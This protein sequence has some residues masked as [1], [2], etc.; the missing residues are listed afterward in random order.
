MAKKSS[1]LMFKGQ[2]VG[3]IVAKSRREA[4]TACAAVK[5]TYSFDGE[6]AGVY[7]I[8]QAK[9]AGRVDPP[10]VNKR[11]DVDAEFAKAGMKVVEGGFTIG[12]Q[13]H[14]CMEKHTSMSVPE[15]RGHIQVQCGSQG[16]DVVRQFTAAVLGKSGLEVEVI[17]RRMGGAFGAKFTKGMFVILAS[18]VAA[19]KL[20]VPVKI[21]N[22]IEVDM[23]MGGHCRHPTEITYKAAVDPAT[24]KI[25]AIAWNATM[26]KGCA[27][28]FS[29]FVSGELLN[30]AECLYHVPNFKVTVQLVQT[31]TPSN[32]AVRGPGIPQA[33]A[34]GEQVIEH[35]AVAIGSDIEA[36]RKHNLMSEDSVTM[37]VMMLPDGTQIPAG[38]PLA[39][40][41]Y[42]IPRIFDELT[43]SSN[44]NAR[45]VAIA[46]F[47]SENKWVKR[48][49]ALMPMRYSHMPGFN[50]NTTCTININGPDGVVNVH[51]GGVEMG[52][53]LNTKVAN[54]IAIELGCSLDNV[55][56]HSSST[57]TT[58]NAGII[59]GSVGSETCTA[60]AYKTVKI[61]IDRMAPI[62]AILVE[63]RAAAAK[64]EGKEPVP[65]TFHE[66]VA[67]CTGGLMEGFKICLAASAN[68]APK[69]GL[70][71]GVA[72]TD[73]WEQ[74]P[75]PQGGYLT[76]GAAVSETEVDVLTGDVRVLRADILYDCGHSTNPL[77]D[78][79]QAEGAFVRCLVVFCACCRSL[80]SFGLC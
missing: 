59:G 74:N 32:T 75:Y 47:N 76:F 58:P 54:A 43:V 35:L 62:K 18:A 21:A 25:A 39:L 9:A 70:A 36:F 24:Q 26:D 8:A 34:M 52:Q 49:I 28:D 73:Q 65:P 7:T 69:E 79:G 29:P 53:G 55:F 5:V 30:H 50:G 16:I 1:R 15:E 67:K 42:T 12:G 31:D 20:D 14:F 64:A 46:K 77:I 41:N 57:A 63:E 4:E 72:G 61:L 80:C 51:H 40:S 11:G 13:S 27:S 68:Y 71:P 66:L 10:V 17:T 22:S 44:I 60:A 2:P 33:H 6:A 19:N 38:M 78:I 45:K 56:V 37:A 3:L 23:V 48:G